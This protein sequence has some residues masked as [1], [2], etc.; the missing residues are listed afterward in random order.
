M[1]SSHTT[2]ICSLLWFLSL[3]CEFCL[4]SPAALTGRHSEHLSSSPAT[5]GFTDLYHTFCNS[6]ACQPQELPQDPFSKWH[7]CY[8]D[9]GPQEQGWQRKVVLCWGRGSLALGCQ[10]GAGWDCGKTQLSPS[11]TLGAQA[12]AAQRGWEGLS[13]APIPSLPVSWTMSFLI[14]VISL[15]QG[16]RAVREPLAL[17][18]G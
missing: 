11:A 3:V 5:H 12:G 9:V 17:S 7:K 14:L 1:R 4:M 8:H 6:P 15:S 16:R 18:Q 2:G 13:T 10:A